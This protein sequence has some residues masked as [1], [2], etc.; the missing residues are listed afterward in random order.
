MPDTTTLSITS[1]L[2]ILLI[3]L[4]FLTNPSE[5]YE[6]LNSKKYFYETSHSL[7]ENY[8]WLQHINNEY[9]E[10]ISVFDLGR[11]FEG[12][13]V[14]GLKISL[15]DKSRK[16][17]KPNKTSK[18][19]VIINSGLHAREW[20]VPVHL[21][22]LVGKIIRMVGMTGDKDIDSE[23]LSYLSEIDLIILPHTNPDG[24]KFSF[25][26]T[27]SDRFWRRTRSTHY[28]FI[29][30]VDA[31]RNFPIAWN[32]TDIDP[33]TDPLSERFYDDNYRG[34]SA[35]SEPSVQ[36]LI[37]YLK[38]M[39]ANYEDLA[40]LDVH[41][42][43]QAIFTPFA[44]KSSELISPDKEILSEMAEEMSIAIE[45]I[46]KLTFSH[47]SVSLL[48][49]RTTG[50]ST[51]YAYEELGIRC[52]LAVEMRTPKDI[53]ERTVDEEDRFDKFLVN[54]EDIEIL[55]EEMLAAYKVVLRNV[56]EGNCWL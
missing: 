52:S 13:E 51:D 55:T 14:K 30:G 12:R 18:K 23:L 29:T 19:A 4:K 56:K 24:Y 11:S 40:Y 22:N 37:K 45:N 39:S 17:A 25:D 7:E 5:N 8:E 16:K 10:F 53:S 46:S 20:A 54:D 33:Y 41:C 35:A 9:S 26:N 50:T 38:R 2:L 48:Y 3:L 36:S 49:G 42:C 47:G 15:P 34:P 1:I 44:Y 27:N 21:I 32:R 43:V 6:L 31:N 28:D